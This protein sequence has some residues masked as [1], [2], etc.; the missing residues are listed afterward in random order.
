MK[1]SGQ[2][3]SPENVPPGRVGPG[4]GLDVMVKRKF[5]SAYSESNTSRPAQSKSLY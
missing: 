1:V 2:L 4:G 5:K 3:P